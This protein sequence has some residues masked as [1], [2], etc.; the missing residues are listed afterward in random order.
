[1]KVRKPAIAEP[2]QRYW[3]A[4]ANRRVRKKRMARSLLRWSLVALLNLAF[5]AAL[6][7]MVL[8]GYDRVR[9]SDEF[10]L[11]SIEIEGAERASAQELRGRLRPFLGSNLLDLD[12]GRVEEIARGDPWVARASVRRVLPR[13]LR[14]T[15]VE[16]EPVALALIEGLPHIVDRTGFVVGPAGRGV[17]DGF[18]VLTGLD[19]K[20]RAE[21]IR[22]LRSGA[23]LIGRLREQAAP[24]AEQ[25]VEL[26]LSRRDRI[27]ARL[28]GRGPRILLDPE[29]IERNVGPFL[30]LRE[31][32]ESRVGHMDYVDLR[33]EDRISVMPAVSALE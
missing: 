9:S 18:P 1:V 25:L 27:T 17:A 32:I 22:A 11:Q 2:D 26:D 4:R 28:I 30:E 5:L 13:T 33:W 31:E 3:R 8:R 29:R 12:L 15:L 24:F 20:T 21:L 10:A 19:G 16:R 7:F 23:W 14:I 6:V